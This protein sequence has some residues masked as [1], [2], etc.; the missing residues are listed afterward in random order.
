[1]NDSNCG[2]IHSIVH[3]SGHG[4]TQISFIQGALSLISPIIAFNV[5]DDSDCGHV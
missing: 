3:D 2:L 4:D 1:M 5:M